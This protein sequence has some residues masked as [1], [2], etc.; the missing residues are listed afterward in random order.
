MPPSTQT[1]AASRKRARSASSGD[2][3][4]GVLISGG[5]PYPAAFVQLWEEGTMCDANLH[6]AEGQGFRAHRNVLAA[7]S[8]YLRAK[9]CGEWTDRNDDIALHE[10]PAFVLRAVLDF[11]YRGQCHLPDASQLLPL[12]EMASF[13]QA[14]TLRES[15]AAVVLARLDVGSC[16]EAWDFAE[17]H[18]LPKLLIAAQAVALRQFEVLVP[19][20]HFVSLPA[21]RLSALMVDDRLRVSSEKV[22][23][24]ALARWY[25]TAQEA[26]AEEILGL[27]QHVRFRIIPDEFVQTT[28]LSAP[29]MN[30]MAAMTALAKALVTRATPRGGEGKLYVVGGKGTDKTHLSS[31]EVFDPQRNV[32][33]AAPSMSVLRSSL[34]AAVLEGNGSCTLWAAQ[35]AVTQG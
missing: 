4:A 16:L 21:G 24:Q 25:S 11:L 6:A 9:L 14:D 30:S 18:E 20:A 1:T 27:L 2:T 31:M 12:L 35:I 34:A 23:F 13:L 3:P 28:V 19:T 8:L 15:A 22:V 17:R 5:E 29:M 7:G 32:W 26:W 33:E 10:A